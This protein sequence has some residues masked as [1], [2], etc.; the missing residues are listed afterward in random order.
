MKFCVLKRIN[1]KGV[2]LIELMIVFAVIAVLAAL[3]VPGIIH[4]MPDYRLKKAGRDIFTNFQRARIEAIRRNTNV[5]LSFNPAA[6]VPQGRVGSYII[7]VDD[8]SGGGI[9]ADDMR[10]GTESILTQRTMP[11]DVSLTTANFNGTTIPGYNARG[12][13]LGGTPARTGNVV[14]QNNN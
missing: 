13:P 2:T 8:G 4:W 1:E 10:N 11:D 5:V 7:F 3:A 12:F 6:F 9:A 14:V